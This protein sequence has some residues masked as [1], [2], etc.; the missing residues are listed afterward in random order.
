MLRI[1]LILF[2]LFY[3]LPCSG[4]EEQSSPE[5]LILESF[6]TELIESTIESLMPISFS[7]YEEII[8]T[9]SRTLPLL[10]NSNYFKMFENNV[11][12]LIKK[13]TDTSM[14]NKALQQ[15]IINKQLRIALILIMAGADFNTLIDATGDTILTKAIINQDYKTVNFLISLF[16]AM[17]R[18][19]LAIVP[20]LTFKNK[21]GKTSLELA[22]DTNDLIITK[23]L[24][25]VGNDILP[26]IILLENPNT[27]SVVFGPL[28]K[29]NNEAV[30]LLL[31]AIRD[32]KPLLKNVL[33]FNDVSLLDTAL[34]RDYYLIIKKIISAAKTQNMLSDIL[35]HKDKDGSNSIHHAIHLRQH[36]SVK[37]FLEVIS[38]HND[39]P[40]L[41]ALL[42]SQNNQGITPL[43]EAVIQGDYAL[44][45]EI[46]EAGE[47]TN[48]KFLTLADTNGHTALT[49]AIELAKKGY[50]YLNQYQP[51]ID[52]LQKYIS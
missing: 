5:E 45:K 6:P 17:Q 3:K 11:A 51:I 39:I 18:R 24:L 13:R 15:A 10:S 43:I 30:A 16:Q 42:E 20:F 38:A 44:V 47:L 12:F 27:G 40:L 4:M 37:L 21:Q 8:S 34:D 25:D 26:Q 9:I 22:V 32:N 19:K 1:F 46:L 36:T 23:L 31:N 48:K 49:K 29:N 33:F 7:N 50:W 41:E 14:L 28:I 52:L 35:T 2:F